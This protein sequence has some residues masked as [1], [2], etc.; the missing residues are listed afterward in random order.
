VAPIYH[1][2]PV[3]NLPGIIKEG[4]L[5][6]DRDAKNIKFVSIGHKHIKER[7]EKK[8]VPNGPGGVVSDYVPFYFAPRSP[9]LYAINRGGVAG[10]AGRQEPIIHLCSSTEA[11][12]EAGLQWVFTEGQAAMD[13]T[14][15]YDDF[16]DLKE[17]DWPLMKSRYWHDTD[18]YP[19]RCRRRQAEFLVYNFF[20]WK[21]VAEVGVCNTLTAQK[22]QRILN[23]DPP[24][25]AIKQDWYY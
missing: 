24:P 5:Y 17:I 20:P 3:D 2:T 13:Y 4:G 6:C 19:D 8:I 23:G 16:K 12:A 9:M 10:Y 22:V 14:D 1:I 18:N 15:F 7:R 21:L 11:V 25:V